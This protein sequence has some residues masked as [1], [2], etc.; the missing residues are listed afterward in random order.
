MPDPPKTAPPLVLLLALCAG[1]LAQPLGAR[2]G[3]PTAAD[4]LAD[5]ALPAVLDKA[6]ALVK[7]GLGAGDSYPEVW[8]R[9][10]NTFVD[11]ALDRDTRPAIREALLAFLHF[12]FA[13]DGGIPDGYVAEAGATGPYAYLSA[14]GLPGFAAFKN[15][16]E[17]DQESSLVQAFARYVRGTGDRAI[18][19][20]IVAGSPVRARLAQALR[21][22]LRARF[23]ERH[24]LLWGATTIDWGDVQPE[25]RLAVVYDAE[26][27]HRAIDIYDNAMFLI[28][29]D[30]YLDVAG[31]TGLEAERL[32]AAARRMRAAV[33]THLWDEARHKFRPH[34]YLDGSPFPEDFDE[35]RIHYHGGTAVAIEAGLLT[36]RE[37]RLVFRDMVNNRRLAGAASIGLTIYP[38]Y[39]DGLFRHP[40]VAPHEY[41]NGG[42]WTWFG[43]RMVQQLV[44]HGLGAEAYAELRPMVDR[45]ERD[46]G[47]YEWYTPGNEPRGSAT[48]RGAA[49]QLGRAIEMLLSW[50]RAQ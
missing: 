23:S 36:D 44:A 38:V 49:G 4:V 40:I 24:G 14:A 33:R 43:A 5:R 27:S 41:Q 25:T 13:S 12:Q 50:A 16:V 46:N 15:T 19:D 11:L 17:T 7:S 1:G 2:A 47:F 45:V 10:L 35:D 31:R 21:F 34:I 48:Y 8:I 20:D 29:V 9:D 28:A 22:P 39:P 3:D 37:V 6:R 30:A 42:D 32:A 26:K 18:L